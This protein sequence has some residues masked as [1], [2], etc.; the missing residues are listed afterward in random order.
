MVKASNIDI[1]GKQRKIKNLVPGKCRFP[2]KYRNKPVHKCQNRKDGEWCATS[3]DNNDKTK[4][5]GY[6]NKTKTKTKTNKTKTNK[7]KTKTNKTKTNKTNKLCPIDKILNPSTGRCVKKNGPLGKKLMSKNT[8]KKTNKKALNKKTN[9]K[10]LNKKALNKNIR[11][12]LLKEVRKLGKGINCDIFNNKDSQIQFLGEGIAN[13][14][15][16]SC[17]NTECKRRVAV[18]LMSIDND[19]PYNSDHP[20]NVEMRAYDIFNKLLDENITQH[21]PYKITNFKCKINNL[22]NSQLRNEMGSYKLLL[23]GGTI[24]PELDILITEYCKYGSAKS[25]LNKNM[26]KMND[27]DLQ[28]FIFQFLSGLVTLQYHIPHFK[29]NDIHNENVLVGTYNLKNKNGKNKNKYIKYI[30]FEKEYYIPL[31]DFCVKIYDF[32]TIYAKNLNNAK[33]NEY[34]LKVVGVSKK[35]N[36]VFDYHLAMNS[37][38]QFEDFN[39]I[40]QSESKNFFNKQ[41]PIEY[42]GE[43]NLYLSYARLTNYNVTYD[44]DN[45]NLIP[46]N[47]ATPSDVLLNNNYFDIFR[48]K[49]ANCIIVDVI[50]SKIPNYNKIKH[51][52]YMFK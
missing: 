11:N 23:S 30:L 36:P 29:H 43:D 47:I 15:Y 9:K 37:L 12:D 3:V 7:T 33:I 32:D 45:T 16:L 21:I 48:K 52:K 35:D 6:C 50:D 13:K 51:L 5:W 40:K 24:K 42:R 4:T 8:T 28:I 38:F 44:L 27:I 46:N 41:I 39:P 18:R 19:Y 17:L 2:F 49:P 1:N 14:V 34:Y 26:Y 10:A 22:V 25:Y 31:R 20:N